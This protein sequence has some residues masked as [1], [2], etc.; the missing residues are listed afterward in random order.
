MTHTNH[1]SRQ[2]KISLLALGAAAALLVSPRIAQHVYA[3]E[4]QVPTC[5]ANCAKGSCTGTGTCTCTCSWWTGTPTCSCQA[6]GGG[7]GGGGEGG[8]ENMT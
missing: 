5:S 3:Q 8:G 4:Q 6:S 1:R 2:F 7:G